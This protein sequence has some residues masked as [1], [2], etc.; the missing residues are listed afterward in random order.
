MAQAP[1]H[2]GEGVASRLWCTLKQS[3]QKKS[4][5][6]KETE[7][8]TAAPC[9]RVVRALLHDLWAEA[10][11]EERPG[12]LSWVSHTAG[13]CLYF[14]WHNSLIVLW[15]AIQIIHLLLPVC[16]KTLPRREKWCKV[17]FFFYIFFFFKPGDWLLFWA[18]SFSS[19]NAEINNLIRWNYM[20]TL[21]L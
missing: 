11:T 17:C 13:D 10:L 16:F 9:D 6:T 12:H 2:T 4:E 7:Q 5:W 15:L 8:S 21:L 14:Y 19:L 18:S 1:S 20:F 3:C